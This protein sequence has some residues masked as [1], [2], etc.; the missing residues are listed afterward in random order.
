M[1]RQIEQ[2]LGI[3]RRLASCRSDPRAPERIAHGLDEIIRFRMLMIAAG[4]EDGNDANS[5]RSDPLYKLAMD[6]LAM[7]PVGPLRHALSYLIAG[8]LLEGRKASY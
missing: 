6:R 7:L 2:W 8:S 5:L 3:V 1:L 4:Y